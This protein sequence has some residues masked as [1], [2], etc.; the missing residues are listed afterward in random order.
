M[1]MIPYLPVKDKHEC[2]CDQFWLHFWIMLLDM[3]VFGETQAL[4]YILSGLLT[5][6]ISPS[7]FLT[8]LKALNIRNR[9]IDQSIGKQIAGKTKTV[10]QIQVYTPFKHRKQL[11]ILILET[12]RDF[13]IFVK[14]WLMTKSENSKLRLSQVQTISL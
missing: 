3:A 12:I 7:I 5:V 13:E 11:K 6:D 14:T 8:K 2:N 9:P 1:Q 10:E 4:I